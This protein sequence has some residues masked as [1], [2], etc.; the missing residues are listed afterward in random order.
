M[1]NQESFFTNQSIF[2][3]S[4]VQLQMQA[5]SCKET[6]SSN[7]EVFKSNGGTRKTLI[8]VE[9]NINKI[10]HLSD[11]VSWGVLSSSFKVIRRVKARI[12]EYGVIC[13]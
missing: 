6:L 1:E 3:M 7:V 4:L 5:L 8:K 2:K 13:K 9:D 11:S 10:L 12:E